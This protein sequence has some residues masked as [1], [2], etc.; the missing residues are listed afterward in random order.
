MS[1]Q[2]EH[3]GTPCELPEPEKGIDM[4]AFKSFLNNK[5]DN[6]SAV[7]KAIM[8]YGDT[9]EAEEAFKESPFYEE[10]E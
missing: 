2:L 3:F 6:M 8:L 1:E 4:D 10:E 9:F 5:W 7:N